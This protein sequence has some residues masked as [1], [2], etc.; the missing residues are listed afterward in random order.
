MRRA[1][2]LAG[3]LVLLAAQ[4]AAG[5][6]CAPLTGLRRASMADGNC[7]G[8]VCE[9]P[10]AAGQAAGGR[11]QLRGAGP[12]ASRVVIDVYSDPA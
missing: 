10:G 3:T 2:L 12:A 4:A 6:N 11:L 9:R 8:G 5:Y 7:D 1:R